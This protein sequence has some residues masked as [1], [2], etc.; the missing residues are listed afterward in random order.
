MDILRRDERSAAPDAPSGSPRCVRL[1]D[2]HGF[3]AHGTV[4]VTFSK[5]SAPSLLFQKSVTRSPP[6]T[7]LCVFLR[8]YQCLRPDCR[9]IRM[10]R[11]I[12]QAWAPEMGSRDSPVG[13]RGGRRP[14]RRPEVLKTLQFSLFLRSARLLSPLSE[15]CHKV[16]TRSQIVC[17]PKTCQWLAQYCA[18]DCS[19]SHIVGVGRSRIILW[20]IHLAFQA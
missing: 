13:R 6:Q 1:Y 17:F 20:I 9:M 12:I 8:N 18:P 7:R 11:M 2:F 3:G 10:I 16:P 5:V 15:I 4:R 19:H 14:P